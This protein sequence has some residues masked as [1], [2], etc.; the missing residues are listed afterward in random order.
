MFIAKKIIIARISI[1]SKETDLG[2]HFYT[3]VAFLLSDITL[4]SAQ[5]F[6]FSM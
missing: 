3:R 2:T 4:R 1:I 5:S 6:V